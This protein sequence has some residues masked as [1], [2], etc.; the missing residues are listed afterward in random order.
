MDDDPLCTE[1]PPKHSSRLFYDRAVQ[2]HWL[3]E[4]VV[5]SP[6]AV[7]LIRYVAVPKS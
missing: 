2:K 1:E 4:F 3:Y 7:I 6:I 5:C